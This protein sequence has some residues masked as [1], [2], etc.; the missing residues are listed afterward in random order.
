MQIK[1]E[2]IFLFYITIIFLCSGLIGS[3]PAAEP[4]RVLILPFNIHADKDLAFLRVGVA[5]ML[6]SRLAEKDKVVVI[7]RTD[8]DLKQ[9]PIPDPID[10]ETALAL[11][12]RSRS[13][14]VLF[15]SLTVFGN[16]ISTDAKFFDA[17]RNQLVLTF[18]EV[19]N[20][21][22]EVI[23]HINLLATRI[24]EEVFGR[25]TVAQQPT[26]PAPAPTAQSTGTA[27]SESTTRMHPEKLL[28]R[29]SGMRSIVADEGFAA[30]EFNATLWRTQ[31]F[32][33]EINGI[34]IGD[35]DGDT[36][37]EAVFIGSK[38]LFVYR[39]AD[40][41][42]QKITEIQANDQ[43]S[44][45][46]VDSA[47][48]NANG[49]AEIFVTSLSDSNRLRSFVLEW[50]GT[51][52]Q[53]LAEGENWYFRVIRLPD[54][55]APMLVGQKGG[56]KD[57]FLGDIYELK[58]D[59]GR[60]TPQ[61]RQPLPR[62]ASVYGFTYGDVFNSGQQLVLALTTSSTLS[63]LDSTG[64][65]EWTSNETYGGSKTYLLSPADLKEAKTEGQ[66]I[67]PTAF[68]GQY[69][70]QRIF[71][72]DLDKDK[73]N[74]V[75]VVKNHDTAGGLLQRFKHY[76]SGHFE[77][78]VW[79]NVGLRKKWI[80]RKFSGYIGDFDVGDLDNDGTAELVFSITRGGGSAFTEAKSYIVSMSSK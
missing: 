65:E 40:R 12:E 52:F 57:L 48:I 41:R 70:Q 42:F 80:T 4:A 49:T 59:S 66:R 8:P 56:Y 73:Q 36:K 20:S 43:D 79:D 10:I 28:D 13:D 63:I 14:Y 18:S 11:G 29:E 15:G 54:R 47:D 75:I 50:N 35:V 58:W 69:L 55:N 26:A 46:G 62:W 72:A 78:L 38:T 1:K 3:A 68:K 16:S 37:N 34:T 24:K 33:T 19:G 7:D 71:V 76:N 51:E 30:G 9:E 45:I 25:K 2:T 22:G 60:Y 64:K 39:Y 67:D 17:H 23:S 77:G 61:D 53:T 5:D 74:E 21:H 6:A 32:K 27:E 44:F 31:D